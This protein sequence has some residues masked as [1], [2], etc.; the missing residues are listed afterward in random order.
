MTEPE[1]K[2]AD[3]QARA[4]D[5]NRS[6]LFAR[7]LLALND[8]VIF[9]VKKSRAE[10]ALPGDARELTGMAVFGPGQK[11]LMDLL[12]RPDGTV[13]AE[14]LKKH[15]A[16][17]AKN[18]ATATF[19]EV[20]RILQNGFA[21]TRVLCFNPTK[22]K[23]LLSELC[24]QEKLPPVTGS[25]LDLSFEYS[26]FVGELDPEGKN[27]RTQPLPRWF[28]CSSAG[29]SPLEEC[30]HLYKIL[31]SMASSSQSLDTPST[32]NRNW[33]ATFYRPK[34]GAADKLKEMLGLSKE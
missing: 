3:L 28:D 17:A 8:W 12:V 26:R 11:V 6:I 32:F 27:Y 22:A 30:Q 1:A 25:F 5:R 18:P 33:S 21:R 29:V 24:R 20:H 15:S 16:K 7:D 14:L 4:L 13:S 34:L 31:S 19:A 2:Q 10:R 9:A 23:D